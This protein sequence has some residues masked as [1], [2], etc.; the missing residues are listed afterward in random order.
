MIGPLQLIVIGF[1]EDKYARD[2]I[3]EI[4]NLRQK[5]AIRLFDLLYIFKHEDGTIDSQE[6]SD[7]QAEEQREFGTLIKSL[8]GLSTK[9]LDHADADE[10][11]ASI[12]VAEKE[13]GVSQSELQSF[14][15]DLP[16][17]SSAI[18]VAFE[19]VWA[20]GF[21]QA[22]IDNNGYL[23]AAGMIDPNT[24]KLAADELASVLE[25][26]DKTE[27]ASMEKM[28]VI[29]A[30]TKARE[31]EASAK[32]AA[33]ESEAEAIEESAEARMA[34][35][36]AL[37]VMAAGVE[38]EALAREEAALKHADEVAHEV[39]EIEDQAFLEAEAVR[40]V[41]QRQKE[42]ALA[43][44]AEVVQESQDIEAAAVLRAVNALVMADLIE[45]E[46]TQEALDA[47]F[48]A[49]VIEASAARRAARALSA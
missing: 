20:R 36:K 23:R 34:R 29:L 32:A 8:I 35:A 28:A 49:R 45:Q 26:I 2:I 9:D 17:G 40:K 19:H 46:A 13:F 12:H 44:A 22:I 42:E 1:D 37:A 11:A 10:V 31:D 38:I 6:V 30:A 7:L 41:A 4:K 47:I 16:N 21:K 25:A 3:L 39:E 5:Q 14:A 43:D 33:V 27:K 18:F 48:A 15:D 24:L